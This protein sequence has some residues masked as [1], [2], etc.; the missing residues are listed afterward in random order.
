MKKKF[1]LV[2]SFALFLGGCT[3]Y[4]AARAT[5]LAQAT[6][7]CQ[8]EGKQ[9]LLI[10]SQQQGGWQPS[11]TIAGHCVGPGDPGYVSA[12]TPVPVK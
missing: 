1:A 4:A 8:A 5:A 7:H 11:V 2:I 6:A 9:F 12:G 10:D 3:D